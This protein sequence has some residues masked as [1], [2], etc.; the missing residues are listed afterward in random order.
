MAQ[1][2]YIQFRFNQSDIVGGPNYFATVGGVDV[3]QHVEAFSLYHEMAIVG[4]GR[5]SGRA[6]HQPV[7]IV[8]RQDRASPHFLTALDNNHQVEA[9]IRFF[10]PDPG[11]P[12]N[13]AEHY[14][15]ELLGGRITSVRTEMLNNRYAENVPLPVMERISISYATLTSTNLLYNTEAQI[16]LGNTT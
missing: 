9:I 15:L 1:N 4:D 8:K 11:A 6:V 5:T 3:S 7:T 14:R 12:Q 10:G 2:I 13:F 16:S